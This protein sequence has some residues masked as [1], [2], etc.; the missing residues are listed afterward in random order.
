MRRA[1]TAGSAPG[2]SGSGC[3]LLMTRGLPAWIDVVQ[4]VVSRD[5]DPVRAPERGGDRVLDVSPPGVR[6]DLTR[7]LAG[8]VLACAQEE[9]SV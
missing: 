5:T 2:P 7:L 4:R 3:V 9:V 8:L 6:A 1:A